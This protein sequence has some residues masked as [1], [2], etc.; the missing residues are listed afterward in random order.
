MR[1]RAGKDRSPE[2][3]YPDS[4]RDRVHDIMIFRFARAVRQIVRRRESFDSDRRYLHSM[5]AMIISKGI[6]G[7]Q[8]QNRAT[9]WRLPQLG[10]GIDPRHLDR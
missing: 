2:A 9:F 3:V 6:E 5:P 4:D 1:Q 8:Q 10:Q 7:V